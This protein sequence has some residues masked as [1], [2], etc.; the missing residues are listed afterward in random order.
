[1]HLSFT[2]GRV[3]AADEERLSD[4]ATSVYS[5][6]RLWEGLSDSIWSAFL[7]FPD[8]LPMLSNLLIG[9]TKEPHDQGQ[10]G[11]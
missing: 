4:Q 7:L 8:L 10:Q 6:W 5:V 11:E 3:I 2:S 9:R 1:M